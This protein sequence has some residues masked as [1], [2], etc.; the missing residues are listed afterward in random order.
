[1]KTLNMHNH[2]DWRLLKPKCLKALFTKFEALSIY[3]KFS[4]DQI[5]AV[6]A[7]QGVKTTNTRTFNKRGVV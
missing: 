2:L 7:I 1:M 5:E 4:G 3:G 6:K